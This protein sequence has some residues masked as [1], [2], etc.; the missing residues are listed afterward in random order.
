M[1]PGSRSLATVTSPR[2]ALAATAEGLDDYESFNICGPE[3][4]TARIELICEETGF[5]RPWFSV[6]YGGGY[7]FGWLMENLHP[8]LPGASPFLTR[9]LVHVSEDWYCPGDYAAR[10]LGYVPCKNW[11]VAVREALADRA[12][13]GYRWPRLAQAA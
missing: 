9:S 12:A 6:P 13:Q 4:P 1:A 7:A 5:P 11:R 10:K 8:V 2:P 3:F